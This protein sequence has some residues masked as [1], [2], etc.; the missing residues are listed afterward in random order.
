MK[1]IKKNLLVVLIVMLGVSMIGCSDSNSNK[2][3]SG[4]KIKHG[5]F[6]E[7][8]INDDVLVIKAKIE[9]SL[10]NKLTISQNGFNVEDIIKNQGGDQFKEIQYWAVADMTSGEE[11]KVVSFTLNEELIKKIKAGDIVANQIINNA[12][13]VY[14]LPS[15]QN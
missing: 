10:N 13:D 1:M 14:I 7:S 5:E 11:N 3:V 8:N 9:P 12:D 4:Y 15:L 6:I 2:E